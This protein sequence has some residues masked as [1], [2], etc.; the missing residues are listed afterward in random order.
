MLTS[1]YSLQTKI[2]QI[3]DQQIITEAFITS[4]LFILVYEGNAYNLLEHRNYFL[5]QSSIA[6]LQ[7]CVLQ[8]YSKFTGVDPYRKAISKN[9]ARGTSALVLYCKFAGDLQNISLEEHLWGL[10]LAF[11]PFVFV[12]Y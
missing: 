1:Y 12:R 9:V 4:T 2:L 5:K 10:A 3:T 11:I 7:K 8:I 6:S